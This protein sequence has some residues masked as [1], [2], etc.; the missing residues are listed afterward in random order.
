MFVI[1]I[2]DDQAYGWIGHAINQ[3]LYSCH[4]SITV[5]ITMSL[6]E[7]VWPQFAMKLFGGEDSMVLVWGINSGI[8][9]DPIEQGTYRKLSGNR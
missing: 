7:A 8:V 3:F 6:T 4:M 1:R 5:A 2:V 9:G